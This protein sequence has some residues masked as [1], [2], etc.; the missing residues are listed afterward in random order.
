MSPRGRALVPAARRAPNYD[1]KIAE[2]RE[3]LAEQLI[4]WLGK[5]RFSQRRF[6]SV[7]L[8]EI[9]SAYC[10]VL[11]PS[12]DDP[13]A[14]RRDRHPSRRRPQS[15]KSGFDPRVS[16]PRKRAAHSRK[17]ATHSEALA[18]TD[19]ETPAAF[20]EKQER[21]SA[22]VAATKQIDATDLLCLQRKMTGR[23]L[24]DIADELL[25]SKQRVYQRIARARRIIREALETC[26]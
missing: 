2:T 26:S 1:G 15:V 12:I 3:E 20:V 10:G 22:I 9:N 19:S 13:T 16:S 5:S 25:C 18:I 17:S 21:M 7:D 8:A 11:P 24:I 14:G 6:P 23:R 4:R